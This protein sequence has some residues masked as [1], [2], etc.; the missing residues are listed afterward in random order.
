MRT[1]LVIAFMLALL[2]VACNGGPSLY[3]RGDDQN[4]ATMTIAPTRY[5]PGITVTG[6]KEAIR[7]PNGQALFKP[8]EPL[9]A[10]Q[11]EAPAPEAAP[12]PAE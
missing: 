1:R 2:L 10:P 9:P 3:I 4:G 7:V 5:T 8:G 6:I 12:V 11:P